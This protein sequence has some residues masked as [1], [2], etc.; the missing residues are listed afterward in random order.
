MIDRAA[1]LQRAA[2][3]AS[4]SAFG[5]AALA[6]RRDVVS[7]QSLPTV[8]LGAVMSDDFTPVYYA[9]RTG[10]FTKA[11]IDVELTVL[12][13]GGAITAAV[14]GGSLDI[15]HSSLLP[16]FSA[17]AKGIPVV[18]VGAGARYDASAPLGE[19][20]RPA[21]TNYASGKD[22]TG[23]TI[24]VSAL[25]DFTTLVVSMWVDR[26]GGDSKQLR[27]VEIPTAAQAPAVEEQ[28][29]DAAFLLN[30]YLAEA[31]MTGK[32]KRL[33][34]AMNAIGNSYMFAAYFAMSDWAASHREL[35]RTFAK[36]AADAA[37]FTNA[38]HDATVAMMADATKI[39][40]AVISKMDRAD[41]FTTLEP[42][43]IQPLID[44][45]A[46]YKMIPHGFPARE[47]IFADAQT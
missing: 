41:T 16:L 24:A 29:V 20:V 5:A 25:G 32:V 37:A 19:L 1:F 18:L 13:S 31:L 7:A 15:G 3:W 12:P 30:P 36:V 38:H 26:T 17:H 21:D 8:R 2:T 39:P 28:R 4:A 10:Q 35:V 46:R 6:A 11:G 27:F 43:P 33:A 14:I 34:A 22:L 9:L 44:F 45:A 23:K 42:A 40:L 47:M